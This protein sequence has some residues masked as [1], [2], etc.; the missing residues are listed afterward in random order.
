MRWIKKGLIFEPSED[1]GWMVTHAALPFAEV[2]ED[3]LRVYFSGRDNKQRAQIGYFDIDLANPKEILRVS[4][5]PVFCLGPLG[6]FDDHGVTMS[7]IVNH[8]DKQYLYYT[9]WHL[10]VTVPFYFYVGLAV[11]EGGGRNFKRITKAPVLERNAIDP[12]LTASPCVLVEADVWRMWYVSGTNWEKKNGRLKHYYHIKYAESSDGLAWHRGG[13]V[14]IDFQSPDEYAI[15]RPCVL[16]DNDT[17][18]MWYS[19]RGKSYRIGYA[20]SKDG[21]HWERKDQEAGIGVSTAG[22]DEEMIEYPYV[23]DHEGKRYMLYNG[24]DYGRTGIGLAE[25]A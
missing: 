20:E 3:C 15:S 2:V 14:C 11:R 9:G 22:W 6:T 10:G 21:L 24:N 18:K 16:K 7:W 12:Y 23:F 4:D 13:L 8:N 5:M 19:Y 25:L 17:Y 1:L